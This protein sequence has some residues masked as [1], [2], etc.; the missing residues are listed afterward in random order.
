MKILRMVMFCV[1]DILRR[2]KVES[3][4]EQFISILLLFYSVHAFG[5]EIFPEEIVLCF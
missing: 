1:K 2:V 5:I 3:R 4:I